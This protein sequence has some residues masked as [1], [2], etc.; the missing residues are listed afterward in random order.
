MPQIAAAHTDGINAFAFQCFTDIQKILIR[1][2]NT[3]AISFKNFFVINNS[4]GRFHRAYRVSFS[5]YIIGILNQIFHLI[6]DFS[7][8]VTVSIRL[9]G[10]QLHNVSQ[11]IPRNF[12]DQDI[13][14]HFVLIVYFIVNLDI[15][16]LFLKISHCR[17][18]GWIPLCILI[19]INQFNLNLVF[20]LSGGFCPSL[21]A[22]VVIEQRSTQ[23]HK[24]RY[25][26]NDTDDQ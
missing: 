21:V 4:G 1:L 7:Q 5:A 8:C 9:R 6:W 11:F 17:L 24:Q 19:G 23:D 14:V 18:N 16:I 25:Q 22:D 13:L 2:R 12:F 10:L 15:R 3:Q 26:N 20:I